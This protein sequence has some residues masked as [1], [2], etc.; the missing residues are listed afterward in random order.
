MLVSL[1]LSWKETPPKTAKIVR[2]TNGHP[3]KKIGKKRSLFLI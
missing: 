2:R 3:G 1:N